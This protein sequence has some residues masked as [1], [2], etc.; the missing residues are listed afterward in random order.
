M[1]PALTPFITNR[2]SLLD[3]Q[4]RQKIIC[5]LL[6]ELANHLKKSAYNHRTTAFSDDGLRK[7]SGHTHAKEHGSQD[8]SELTPIGD[9]LGRYSI[10][11]HVRTQKDVAVWKGLG[12]D[13]P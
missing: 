1:F 2:S 11:T 6:D 8:G 10:A 13:G 9:H 12:R 5:S 7:V 3:L 4:N